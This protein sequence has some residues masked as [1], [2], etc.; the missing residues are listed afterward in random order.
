MSQ[1]RN[2]LFFSTLF[3]TP[4]P[5]PAFRHHLAIF[6]CSFLHSLPFSASICDKALH[7]NGKPLQRE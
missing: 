7:Y 4:R 5:E 2:L 6:V 3:F 1:F